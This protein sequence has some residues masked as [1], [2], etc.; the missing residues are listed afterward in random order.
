VQALSKRTECVAGATGTEVGDGIPTSDGAEQHSTATE[1]YSIT[2]G[3]YAP[4]SVL[5]PTI[6]AV[7]VH[8]HV[9]KLSSKG[10]YLLKKVEENV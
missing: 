4:G 7:D 8:P 2:F 9:D 10:Y 5:A 1:P 6:T 3:N